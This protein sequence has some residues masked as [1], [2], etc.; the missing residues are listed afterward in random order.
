VVPAPLMGPV[1][2]PLNDS[3]INLFITYDV[4]LVLTETF[5]MCSRYE[6]CTSRN[7]FCS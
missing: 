2:L 5:K 7:D 1:V 3:N 6:T 4:F